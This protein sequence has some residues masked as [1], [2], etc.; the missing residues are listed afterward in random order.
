MSQKLK[1]RIDSYREASD[2]KI[3]N[4]LPIIICVNGRA[5]SKLTS[6]IDKPYCTK[7]AE[8]MLSATLKL[9]MEIEGALFAY[10]HNDEIIIVARNDQSLETAAW[11]DNKIQKICSVVSSIATT[12]F[13]N[14]IGSSDLN[15]IGDPVFSA[16]VFAVPTI[17]E[18]I[19]TIVYK[20]QQNFHTSIQL[21][22]F[23]ELLKRHDKNT[24]KEMLT[25]LSVDEKV[26]LLHEECDIDFNEYP[27]SFRRGAA[28]YKVPKV[29]EGSVVKN[30]WILNPELPIFTKDQSF[31]TNIFKNGADIFRKESL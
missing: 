17:S 22:C 15:L 21:A 7:F 6:L 31:L 10:Q 23:Y 30:K 27:H 20:Q 19:N 11:Y 16:Q 3:L 18:A 26:D 29:V 2:Y 4:R 8:G 13:K 5:F 1:D 28:C 24:I 14:Y 12:H 25:G 9:C